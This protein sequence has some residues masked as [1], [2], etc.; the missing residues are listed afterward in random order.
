MY[1]KQVDDRYLQSY[2]GMLRNNV[3][4]SDTA[5]QSRERQEPQPKFSAQRRERER[6]DT[7]HLVPAVP[8]MY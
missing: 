3:T 6:E 7:V 4:M 5:E 1:A 2:L 8:T